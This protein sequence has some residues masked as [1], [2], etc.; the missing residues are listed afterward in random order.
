MKSLALT[1]LVHEGPMARAYLA[2][3]AQA[4]LRPA[5]ALVMAYTQKP[6]GRPAGGR[7]L[8][9][10]LRLAYLRKQREVAE[11]FWP[12]QLR[13]AQ[14]DL[15]ALMTRTI[16][17]GLGV[18]GATFEAVLGRFDYAR[19]VDRVIPVLVRG[20]DDPVLCQA[21]ADLEHRTLLFTGGGI[22]PAT[23]LSLT[24]VRILHVH[25]GRLPHV[26]GADGLLWSTL[27]RGR[28]GASCFY[29]AAG[30]DTGAMVT[31]CDFR[32]LAFPLPPGRRPDDLTLYRALFS[33]YDPLLRTTALVDTLRAGGDCG[34]LASTAQDEGRGVTYH[35]MHPMLRREALRIIFPDS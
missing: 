25:P 31:S 22:V 14:P 1:V 16:G 30:I 7:L 34:R 9:P 12:R 28:P 20:L 10:R 24:G 21:V 17:D 29:M 27:V 15:Y 35:F 11:N 2:G 13:R 3:L 8:P 33:Y 6:D 26:R 32:P 5:A 4:G 23:L 18:D 19:Y